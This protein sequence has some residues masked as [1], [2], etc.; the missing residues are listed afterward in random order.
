VRSRRFAKPAVDP[1]R[2][3]AAFW[4]D[5]R[6]REGGVAPVLTVLLTGAECRFTCVYCDLWRGTIDG[7]TP[8]GA[9]P[10]QIR[11]ALS[12]GTDLPRGAAIKLYNHSNFFDPRAVPPQDDAGVAELVAPFTRVTVECHPNLIGPRCVEF[13][14]R[15]DGKLEVAMG[16]ETVHPQ[17]LA[18]MNKGMT[19]ADFDRAAGELRRHGIGVRAFVLLSPPFIPPTESVEWAVRSVQHALECGA[20]HVSL[21]PVRGGN[22]IMDELE[23]DGAFT[24]PTLSQ[25]EDALDQCLA[26]GG[27]VT[28]DLWDF[29][30]V[31]HCRACASARRTRLT[32]INLSGVAEP[33]VVCA[34]CGG[35]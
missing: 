17:T 29:D 3:G 11:A 27:V 5:E 4:E 35:R 32:R 34:E 16:L 6:S 25:I 12:S 23:R 1:Y 28:A 33:R 31:S 14:A 10:A 7:D 22:G 20:Q 30:R 15:L 24:P 26:L 2:P 9:I 19:V 13:A 21:I 8:A 18:Q